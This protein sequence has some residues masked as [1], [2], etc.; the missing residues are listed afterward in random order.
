MTR[1]TQNLSDVGCHGTIY[2]GNPGL[3]NGFYALRHLGTHGKYPG[4]IMKY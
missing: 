2:D 1:Q 4:I 3:K